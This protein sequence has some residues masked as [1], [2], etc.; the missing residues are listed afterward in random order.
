MD[1]LESEDILD[2]HN[3]FK[4]LFDSSGLVLGL[5]LRLRAINVSEGPHKYR[6]TNMYMCEWFSV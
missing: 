2:I 3:F 4:R 5:W 1:I 6:H